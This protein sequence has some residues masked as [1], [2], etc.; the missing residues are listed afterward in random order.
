MGQVLLL[1]VKNRY[2]ALSAGRSRKLE[3]K[4]VRNKDGSTHVEDGAPKM[5]YRVCN[6][7]NS[8]SAVGLRT[9]R[10]RLRPRHWNLCK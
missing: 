7:S 10:G 4:G 1:K 2:L 8:L 9:A 5:K 3:K 6:M